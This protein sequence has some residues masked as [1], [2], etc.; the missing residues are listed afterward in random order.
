MDF[1][2]IFILS[3]IFMSRQIY[4]GLPTTGNCKSFFPITS[5]SP[6][7]QAYKPFIPTLF[8]E[9]PPWKHAQM[10]LSEKFPP[11]I[12]TQLNTS[13]AEIDKMRGDFSYMKLALKFRQNEKLRHDW[14]Q[15]RNSFLDADTISPLE[16]TRRILENDR[17]LYKWIME[18][19]AL[20]KKTLSEVHALLMKN[21]IVDKRNN[22]VRPGAYRTVDVMTDKKHLYPRHQDVQRALE[23]FFSW[24]GLQKN[25]LHP[26]Q[27]AAQTYQWIVSIQ[28]F[29]NGNKRVARWLV[30]WILIQ[31][32]YPPLTQAH[33]WP[34]I[35]GSVF[36]NQS[37]E[38]N[39]RP[40]EFVEKIQNYIKASVLNMIK[41]SNPQSDPQSDTQ[42]VSP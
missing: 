18:D 9:I 32:D 5:D 41:F 26:I 15:L 3:L 25:Q 1:K 39:P 10:L 22:D 34:D 8:N 24:Y 12:Q 38:N 42:L 35:N 2:L 31:H 11:H 16:V 29:K 36:G 28:P 4:A 14:A 13:N 17:L 6:T 7:A 21:N 20:D 40:W 19:T 23:D 37:Y 30:D 33:Y 27:L